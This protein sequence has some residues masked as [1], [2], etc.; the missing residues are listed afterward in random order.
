MEQTLPTKANKLD[1]SQQIQGKASLNE[2]KSTMAEVAANIESKVSI[3]DY[4][5]A[6][7][8]KL[9]RAE[10]NL[11]MQEKVSYEDMKR[12]VTTNVNGGANLTVDASGGGP[13]A[14][15]QFE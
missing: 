7:D 8:E 5:I 9:S 14:N 10:L 4:R 1:V 13:L 11:R 15:R 2:I 12:Y 6:L 3:E